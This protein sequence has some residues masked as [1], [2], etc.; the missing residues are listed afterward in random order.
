MEKHQW[1]ETLGISAMATDSRGVVID[2]NQEAVCTFAGDG[3][4]DLIG[5]NLADDQYFRDGYRCK[6]QCH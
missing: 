1:I 3:G 2:M 5:K 4:L 6:R